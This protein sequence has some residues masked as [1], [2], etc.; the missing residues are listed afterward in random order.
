[1]ITIRIEGKKHD[2][3]KSLAER[4]A[5]AERMSGKVVFVYYDVSPLPGDIPATGDGVIVI[6]VLQTP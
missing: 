2:A 1:M 3:I 4:I 5:M 6:I